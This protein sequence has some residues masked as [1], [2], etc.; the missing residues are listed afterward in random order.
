M[1]GSETKDLRPVP[2]PTLLTTQQLLRENL[3]LR[4]VLETRLNGMDKAI[5]L[6]QSTADKFPARIDEKIASLQ[7]VHEEKFN[8]IQVQFKERDVRTE[9]TS[10]DSKV[11]IDAALQATKESS[12]EQN[13]SFALATAKS[14]AGFSKQIDQLGVLIQTMTKAFDDKI[15]DIKERLT[16]SEGVGSGEHQGRVSTQDLFLKNIPTLIGLAISGLLALLM[17]GGI[18]VTVAYAIRKG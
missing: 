8:S 12:V 1:E 6:L 2:D 18:V 3:W 10:K 13:K 4:E 16:R 14:E 5:E 15:D 9:Q 11:A 17:L 7:Q